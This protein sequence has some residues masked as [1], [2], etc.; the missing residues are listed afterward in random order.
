MPSDITLNSDVKKAVILNNAIYPNADSLSKNFSEPPS[1]KELYIIDTIVIKNFFDGLFSV[2]DESPNPA[3]NNSEYF[4]FRNTESNSLPV[5]LSEISV[6]DF[7][8]ETGSDIVFSFEYYNFNIRNYYDYTYIPEI[9]AHL[10]IKRQCLW[11]IYEKDGKILDEYMMNDTVFWSAAG[12]SKYEADYGLPGGTEALRSAFFYA[13]VDCGKR[14]SPSWIQV[15]RVYYNMKDR[16][17]LFGQKDYSFDKEKLLKTT[18]SIN[19]EKAYRAA[20]NLAFIFEREDKLKDSLEW[21]KVAEAKRPGTKLVSEYLNIIRER[22]L[23]KE[24]LD[25]QLDINN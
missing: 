17:R 1:E 18:N 15:S 2:L 11:R 24:K 19:N 13:G 8:E 6:R 25:R 14:I 21:L 20:I 10:E 5:P 3:L 12:Y 7:C 4:E 16:R 22:I 9:H 23:N